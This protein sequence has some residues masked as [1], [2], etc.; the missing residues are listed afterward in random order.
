[1]LCFDAGPGSHRPN[2][3]YPRLP[4]RRYPV[5]KK[6]K[7]RAIQAKR[8]RYAFDYRS[9][10]C[11]VLCCYPGKGSF[12]K[13]HVDTPQSEKIFGSLVVVFPT[14]HEGGT[15][16]LRHRGHEWIFDSGQALAGAAN[17]Q[18]SIGYVAFFSDFE[19]E[20]APVTSGHRVTLTYNFYF[21]DDGPVSDKDAVSEHLLPHNYQ[22][23]KDSVKPSKRYLRTQNSWQRAARLHL[24]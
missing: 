12:F 22:I 3:H 11:L 7:G 16:F 24:D 4:S 13:P 5:N 18:L 1:M 19:H 8:L 15:L 17:D 21:D 23:K 14:S 6:Y 9:S 20:V 2:E 10:Q